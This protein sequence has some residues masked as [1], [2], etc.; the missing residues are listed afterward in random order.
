MKRKI[1]AIFCAGILAAGMAKATDGP[2]YLL[3]VSNERSGNVTVIDGTTDAVVATFPVGKRP[4]GII[5]A[6]LA[7]IGKDPVLGDSPS[8][9]KAQ[10]DHKAQS[11]HSEEGH[12]RGFRH[13][14][15]EDSAVPAPGEDRLG[16]GNVI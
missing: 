2:G 8:T 4:R 9:P 15:V 12:R 13:D 14:G 11:A 10:G 1:G 3:F 7:T 16:K 6:G 5:H